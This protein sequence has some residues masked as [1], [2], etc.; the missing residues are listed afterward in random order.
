[1]KFPVV[2]WI[3]KCFVSPGCYSH[4]QKFYSYSTFNLSGILCLPLS[5]LFLNIPVYGNSTSAVH[6]VRL[7]HRFSYLGYWIY[8]IKNQLVRKP[9]I[10]SFSKNQFRK[11]NWKNLFIK[12]LKP[13]DGGC[14]NLMWSYSKSGLFS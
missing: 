11:W 6:F 4:P 5:G 3:G 1:M 8:S 9:A 13:V 7:K 2:W 10:F 12:L 14:F